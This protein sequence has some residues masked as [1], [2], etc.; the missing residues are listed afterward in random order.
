MNRTEAQEAAAV[1]GVTHRLCNQAMRI[2][3]VDAIVL[4]VTDMADRIASS[5]T[6]RAAANATG[7]YELADLLREDEVFALTLVR[8][9]EALRNEWES[10]A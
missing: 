6:A 3:E 1:A 7:F 4:D 2:T 8:S 5:G 10:R 9:I